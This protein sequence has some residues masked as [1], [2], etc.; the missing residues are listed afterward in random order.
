MIFMKKVAHFNYNLLFFFTIRRNSYLRLF[1]EYRVKETSIRERIFAPYICDNGVDQ[2]LLKGQGNNLVLDTYILGE[3][4]NKPETQPFIQSKF[5]EQT[6][7][8]PFFFESS[9]FF[10]IVL[11]NTSPTVIHKITKNF[12]KRK[13]I[14]RHFYYKK[15]RLEGFSPIR[16]YRSI[17]RWG[18]MFYF[19]KY[20]TSYLYMNNRW[21]SIMSLLL[22]KKITLLTYYRYYFERFLLDLFLSLRGFRVICFSHIK[23]FLYCYFLRGFKNYQLILGINQKVKSFSNDLPIVYEEHVMFFWRTFQY[24]FRSYKNNGNLMWMLINFFIFLCDFVEENKQNYFFYTELS[25]CKESLN[26]HYKYYLPKQTMTNEIYVFTPRFFN[27]QQEIR[28]AKRDSIIRK[29]IKKR[30][31]K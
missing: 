18:G 14:F 1:I 21:C 2:W 13:L 17:W 4:Y 31:K 26:K 30:K 16:D 5:I 11:K 19:F 23:Y 10:N 8:W 24:F 9:N 25:Y 3:S 7:Y 20:I 29:G 15:H 27:K 12:Y 28:K 22:Q 6:I